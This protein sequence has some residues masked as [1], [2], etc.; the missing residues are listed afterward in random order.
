MR[1]DKVIVLDSS[2]YIY[3]K[4]YFVWCTKI[5]GEQK[6]TSYFN[7]VPA[8]RGNMNLLISG[9]LNTIYNNNHDNNIYVLLTHLLWV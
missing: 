8:G 6:R 9:L 2:R 1:Y 4:V 5:A 7:G 3:T